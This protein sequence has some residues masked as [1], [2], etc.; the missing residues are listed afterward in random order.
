MKILHYNI[1]NGMTGSPNFTACFADYLNGEPEVALLM[2]NEYRSSP[3]LDGM[4]TACGFVHGCANRLPQSKNKAAVFGRVPVGKCV[5]APDHL[6]L[7]LL[8]RAEFDLVCYHASPGGV[9]AVLEEIEALLP[10]LDAGRPTLLCGDLN[11]LSPDDRSALL[12]GALT[13]ESGPGRYFLNGELS[14]EALEAFRAAGFEDVR[15]PGRC[16]TVPTRIGRKHEQ[17]VRLRLDYCLSR[18]LAVA[19]ACVMDQPPFPE[20]SDHYPLLITL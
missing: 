16:E 18:G 7:V 15:G 4:L 8:R 1:L 12:Y 20:I 10:L 13:L 5:A 11:S 3:V 14:F 6:R 2:L 9:A 17:G 19:S